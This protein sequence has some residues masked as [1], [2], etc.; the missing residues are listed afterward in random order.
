[1]TL[2]Q[3][4]ITKLVLCTCAYVKY[5]HKK[6]FMY[7]LEDLRFAVTNFQEFMEISTI[8]YES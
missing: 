4:K 1:M 7:D 2:K 5:V 3:K 8:C 6:F